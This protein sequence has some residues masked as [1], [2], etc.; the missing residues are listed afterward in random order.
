M[1]GEVEFMSLK[2]KALL[3]GWISTAAK[4]F[5]REKNIRGENLPCP[6]EDWMYK[7]CGMKKQT[8][9]NYKN[10]YKLMKIV[11]KLMNCRVSMTYFVLNHDIL[12]NY[13]KEENKEEPW[14]HSVP[15]N[16]EV[17]NSYLTEQTI[18]S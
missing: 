12:F 17:C 13:F 9:Y 2:N 5:R 3:G 11:P 18:T 10:L 15:C 14:K 4:V 8:T 1:I 6:F 16:C 7:E